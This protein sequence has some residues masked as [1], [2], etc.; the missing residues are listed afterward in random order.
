MA[1]VFPVYFRPKNC[2]FSVKLL[3]VNSSFAS[4]IVGNFLTNFQAIAFPLLLF[5]G[6]AISSKFS[7]SSSSGSTISSSS[8][9]VEMITA[10]T[11]GEFYAAKLIGYTRSK[12]Y[13][14]IQV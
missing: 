2:S 12:I 5:A 13:R 8:I 11:R 10:K 9:I 6:S 3:R 14:T 1:D 7:P 4:S